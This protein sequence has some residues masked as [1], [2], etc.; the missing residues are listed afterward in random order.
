MK[1]LYLVTLC[2]ICLLLVGAKKRPITL[3]LVGDSTMAD[4][5]QL[6]ASP[7]RG[8]G[9]LFPT[10]LTPDILV[11]NHARNGRSTRTFISEG[12]WDDVMARLKKGDVVIIQF[13]H[14]DQSVE[15]VDRYT[16]PDTYRANLVRMVTDVRSKRATPILATSVT[17]RSFKNGKIVSKHGVYPAIVL[18]IGKELQVDV[19]D[20]HASSMA[21]ID[22]VGEEASKSLYMHVPAG[23]YSKYP[24]GKEDNTHFVEAGALLMGHLAADEIRAKKIRPL[25]NYLRDEKD[26]STTYTT[27]CTL[28]K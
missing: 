5:E 16:D 24:E 19:L 22:R 1:K 11:E 26:Y 18:A 27:F 3:F 6:D 14:N 15:K 23:L 10:Y 7:E 20:M 8:W 17:R 9:Q 28:R 25:V 2:F 13:G 12:R 4:K 21:A